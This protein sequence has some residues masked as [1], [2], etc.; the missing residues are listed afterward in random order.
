MVYLLQAVAI[1]G[2]M[3][4]VEGALYGGFHGGLGVGL[5]V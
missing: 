2:D 4:H 1:K 5:G 3:V